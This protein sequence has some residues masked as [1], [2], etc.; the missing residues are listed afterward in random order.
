MVE[1][2]HIFFF[3]IG[4]L[5]VL[6]PLVVY[7]LYTEHR[8]QKFLQERMKQSHIRNNDRWLL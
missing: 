8:N 7:L 1:A 2:G 3:A 5:A 4:A 6:A